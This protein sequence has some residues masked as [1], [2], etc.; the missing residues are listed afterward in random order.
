M[1]NKSASAAVLMPQTRKPK[2]AIGSDPGLAVYPVG[3]A[4]MIVKRLVASGVSLSDALRGTNLSNEAISSPATR[5]SLSQLLTVCGNAA[6]LAR[7]RAFAFNLGLSFH[8]STYGLY[9]FAILS[10]PNLRNAARFT[11]AYQQLASP[12]AK[13][14]FAEK[15]G[16]GIWTISPIRQ[17]AI[18]QNLSKFLIEFQLGI[19]M[20]LLRDVMGSSFVAQEIHLT[21][22]SSEPSGTYEKIFGC[23]VRFGQK[24][25]K[26]IF[27]A[28]WLDS[29]PIFANDITHA[30]M[31]ALCDKMLTDLASHV[32]LAGKVREIVRHNLMRPIGF[33]AVATQ[34][35]MTT[36][37]LRRR[38]REEGAGFQRIFDDLR[39]EVAAEYLRD[40]NLTIEEIA[41]TLG[42][43]D[44][45]N[46]RHAFR[47]WMHMAP[48]KFRD[49]ERRQSE[50]K[51]SEHNPA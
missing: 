14:S 46:F 27:D 35:Q 5:V 15:G 11:E 31:L 3:K 50:R 51:N 6:R 1:R 38:L 9:G 48:A 43:S 2:R 30:E 41:G 36:R 18:D 10:S 37:T 13:I 4:A 47:R 45:A 29:T 25:N 26:L 33:E 19:H 21:Y 12:L 44:A 17:S 23:R 40:T 8:V 49:V 28:A 32:G 20:S 7:D 39:A 34:L 22:D 24:A 42:F 16:R